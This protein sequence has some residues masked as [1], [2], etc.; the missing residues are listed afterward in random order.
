MQL[1]HV[2]INVRADMDAAAIEFRNLRF[3]ITPRG[4]QTL[5]S[6]NH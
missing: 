4:Y 2:V 6:I 5:G 3:T 1:D